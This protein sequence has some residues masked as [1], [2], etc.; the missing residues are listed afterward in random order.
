M[1]GNFL[2]VVAGVPTQQLALNSSAGAGSADE[3]I[4]LDVTGRISQTMMPVGLG[5]DIKAIISAEDLSSAELVQVFDDVGVPKVRKADATA[6]NKFVAS[7]FVLQGYVAP[8]VADVYFEG[9][10]TG[11]SGLTAGLTYY[12]DTTAGGVTATAPSGSGD[13]VQRIG[14]AISATE[15]SFEPAQPIILA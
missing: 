13:M 14:V 6:A 9:V 7:G 10:I 8:A 4:R 11:L 1:A 5:A 3:L 2:D 12:L 15:I